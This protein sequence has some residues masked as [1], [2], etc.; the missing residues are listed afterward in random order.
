MTKIEINISRIS[1]LIA[2]VVAYF[3]IIPGP[4]SAL[5]NVRIPDSVVRQFDKDEY[6]LILL[7][8]KY[9]CGTCPSGK[10][11]YQIA[12][13]PNNVIVIP[14]DYSDN[15]IEN[16]RF[17]FILQGIILRG[18]QSFDILIMKITS[19]YRNSNID[20]NILLKILNKNKINEFKFL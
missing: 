17:A 19:C 16:I 7:Y 10:F 8:E 2:I 20:S 5:K 11:L 1:I 4:C 3:I 6:T 15:D 18:D 14:K 12:V 13:D 9:I